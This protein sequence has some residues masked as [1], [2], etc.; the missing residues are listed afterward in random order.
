MYIYQL[1]EKNN[2]K[3]LSKVLVAGTE[4]MQ[5]GIDPSILRN[6][7]GKISPVFDL[8]MMVEVTKIS[9]GSSDDLSS[10]MIEFESDLSHTH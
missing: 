7:A 2:I 4:S 6:S 10:D 8:R 5:L 3:C 9:H 1:K